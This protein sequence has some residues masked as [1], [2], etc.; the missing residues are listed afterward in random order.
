MSFRQIQGHSVATAGATTVTNILT[1]TPKLGNLICVGV[2]GGAGQLPATGMRVQ[3]ANSNLY[4]MTPSSPR[5]VINS[6]GNADQVWMFYILSAPA[7]VHKNIVATWSFNTQ[8]FIF[9]DEFTSDGLVTFDVD[10]VGGVN[11]V[12]NTAIATPS[13]TPAKSNSLV[14]AQCVTNQTIS[15]PTAGST[16]GSWTGSG[17][18]NQGGSM[19]EY[20]LSVTGAQAVQFTQNT[21]TDWSTMAMVFTE[22]IVD[23]EMFDLAPGSCVNWRGNS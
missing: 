1:S 15:A 10:G 18:A 6:A 5:T 21:S 16:L 8:M 22:T 14:Y 19:A 23:I 4:T 9:A 13:V 12:N 11:G 3:D 17:G 2:S 7:N 20:D